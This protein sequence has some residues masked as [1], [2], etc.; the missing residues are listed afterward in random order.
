DNSIHLLHMLKDLPGRAQDLFVT[1]E[2]LAKSLTCDSLELSLPD[3]DLEVSCSKDIFLPVFPMRAPK[4]TP[5]VTPV[6]QE[7][8]S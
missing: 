7:Y 6:L 8:S 3:L 5:L 1:G 2:N 4:S